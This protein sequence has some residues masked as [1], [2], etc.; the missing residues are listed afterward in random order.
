[1]GLD[2]ECVP[3][4]PG[5]E[6]GVKEPVKIN[7]KRTISALHRWNGNLK[8]GDQGT[9]RGYYALGFYALFFAIFTYVVIAQLQV[10]TRSLAL[11]LSLCLSL[12][13]SLSLL[14]S[15]CL[16]LSRIVARARASLSRI[17]A[18]ARARSLSFSLSRCRS[19]PPSLPLSR[20]RLL[21][22]SLSRSL[23]VSRFRISESTISTD[24]SI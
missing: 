2:L 1:M 24:I 7:L 3:T 4:G 20:P 21:A 19:F 23:F 22:P 17:V 6:E 13:L 14:P 16:S 18:R 10:H 15:R 9:E 12:S 11:S 5:E 8:T